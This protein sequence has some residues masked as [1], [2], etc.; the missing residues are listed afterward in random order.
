MLLN[1]FSKEKHYCGCDLQFDYKAVILKSSLKFFLLSIALQS[2][3]PSILTY[4]SKVFSLTR[5]GHT[6]SS[7]FFLSQFIFNLKNVHIQHR[8][9]LVFIPSFTEI[10]DMSGSS[11]HGHHLSNKCIFTQKVT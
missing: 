8:Y 3:P 11:S 1:T 6:F 4:F 2:P 10:I 9:G 5:S 7:T